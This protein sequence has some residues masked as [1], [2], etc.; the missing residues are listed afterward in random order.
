[1]G[2]LKH[3]IIFSCPHGRVLLHSTLQRVVHALPHTF[4]HVCPQWSVFSHLIWHTKS[5]GSVQHRT[6]CSWPHRGIIFSTGR[7][8]KQSSGWWHRLWHWWS[9]GQLFQHTFGHRPGSWK[10][11]VGWQVLSQAWPQSRRTPQGLWQP[12]RGNAW[13]S[14]EFLTSFSLLCLL[15]TSV[16]SCPIAFFVCK[17]SHIS[18]QSMHWLLRRVKFPMQ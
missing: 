2:S 8:Q 18:F 3:G 7:A 10:S 13:M 14:P 17:S 15:Q 12:P 16:R 1:M 6:V 11:S 9:L 5:F 4:L